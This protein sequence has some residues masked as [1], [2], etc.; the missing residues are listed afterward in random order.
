MSA[1]FLVYF[2][3]G[4]LSLRYRVVFKNEI[5]NI[6]TTGVL[7]LPNH[8]AL[9]DPVLLI[10]I[11]YPKFKPRPLGDENRLRLK[12]FANAINAFRPISI[13]DMDKN[14]EKRDQV[15]VAMDEVV[16]VLN[17]GENALVYPA[18]R[19]YR[20]NK[21]NLRA[22]SAVEYLLKNAPQANVLLVRMNGFWGSDFSWAKGTAPSF[23]SNFFKRVFGIL[24]NGIFFG[25]RRTITIEFSELP[26]EFPREADKLTINRALENFYNAEKVENTYVPYVWWQGYKAKI[27]PE[28]KIEEAKADLS[29]VPAP[30]IGKI[31]AKITEVTGHKNPQ[32][33]DRLSVELGMDSLAIADLMSWVGDEF[34]NRIENLEEVQK[35]SDVILIACGQS[36]KNE[37]SKK[38]IPQAWFD[39]IPQTKLELTPGK[40]IPEVFL[41]HAYRALNRVLLTDEIGGT[42]TFRQVLIGVDLLSQK[43]RNLQ[44]KRIGILLPASSTTTIVYTSTLM[45]NKV[46]VMVNW[47]VGEGVLKSSLD[48]VE[49]TTILT[50]KKMLEKLKS[51]GLDLASLPYTWI[52]L[53]ELAQTISTPAKLLSLVSTYLPW[54]TLKAPQSSDP[55]VILF[56]S[57]SEAKPKAVPL[58]H[59]NL[60]QN[61]YDALTNAKVIREEKLLGMLPP[62]HSLGLITGVLL[63]ITVSIPVVYHANPT[64]SVILA[65]IIERYKP[66]L[67]LGTPTFIYGILRVA[68]KKQLQSIRLIVVGAEKCP[69]YVYAKMQE[70]CP[71]G[72]IVEG[73]GITE[74][75][76]VVCLNDPDAPVLGSLGKVFDSLEYT[77]VHPETYTSIP[78]EEAGLLLVRGPSI[79]QGYLNHSG[80]SPFIKYQDKEWYNTGDL[81]RYDTRGVLFF[82]G[83][84]KRFVKIAG[85]MISLVAIEDILTS[86][87]PADDNGPVVAVEAASADSN[88]ELVLFSRIELEREKINTLIREGGLSGLHNIK[89]VERIDLIPVL[90]TGKTD[91]KS[92]RAQLQA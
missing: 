43:I 42:K 56:T 51:T 81:V 24:A 14:A 70:L 12:G 85:E 84:L 5:P 34:Q 19:V 58:S 53:E 31:K 30:V 10:A 37:V 1:R 3:R 46:P 39:S 18:G 73:Y 28:T 49:V 35:V 91:Y 21:E 8:Q 54:R 4:I 55:A 27:L 79:F 62:F 13:P 6:P 78:K 77:I 63:P 45:A 82:C 86:H 60:L 71:K 22:N 23:F 61:V 32:L 11:L 9:L 66:T 26:K 44:G 64:E 20:E 57:G 83:R 75:S 38:T 92:L 25:P 15:F 17:N 69:D 90:G 47:T 29:Q 88:P 36:T 80:A 59:T 41:N 74:C 68:D 48:S 16:K 89:R 52:Y 40:T 72:I 50:S 76:P 2:I 87:Y 7:I 67:L 33:T 65:D